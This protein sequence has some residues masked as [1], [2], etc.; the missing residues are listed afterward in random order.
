M[1]ETKKA[2]G[3]ELKLYSDTTPRLD[4][5][6]NEIATNR[7]QNG[8]QF[9][10]PRN[11]ENEMLDHYPAE[12]FLGPHAE[13][14]LEKWLQTWYS[15]ISPCVQYLGL[16]T[17]LRQLGFFKLTY[18]IILTTLCALGISIYGPNGLTNKDHLSAIQT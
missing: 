3:I 2:D 16:N 13:S 5:I 1:W 9:D 14:K 17:P 18:V 8:D 10:F 15:L 4:V 12:I 7:T 11:S 6:T